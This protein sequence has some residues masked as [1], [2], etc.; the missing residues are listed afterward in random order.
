MF[1][2]FEVNIN[3]KLVAIK[4]LKITLKPVDIHLDNFESSIRKMFVER[5]NPDVCY[6]NID[7]TLSIVDKVREIGEY[8]QLDQDQ[9]ENLFF[10]GW[11]HDVGYWDGVAL[12]HE[13]RGADFARVFL[14][15][16]GIAQERIEAICGAILAT[17]VP[18]QPMNL[19]ESIICDADLYHL[20]SDQ[21]YT[22]TLLLKKEYEQLNNQPVDLLDWLRNSEKFMIGHHY[23]TDYALRFYK[24]GKDENLK[25]LQSKIEE[26]AK[27]EI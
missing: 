12:D 19:I 2:A 8:N 11:L 7:H 21:C 9:L 1:K 25:F 23:H 17:K 22:Q 10:A 14:K 15:S 4:F 24:P 6:H 18:Q 5:I 16:F 13:E 20:S 27:A 26:L 3:S